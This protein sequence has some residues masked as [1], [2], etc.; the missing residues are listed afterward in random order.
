MRPVV[1]SRLGLLSVRTS[2]AN[3]PFS[4]DNT[5][6]RMKLYRN[7]ALNEGQ[8]HHDS[9][10]TLCTTGMSVYGIQHAQS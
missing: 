1:E 2:F 5:T 6:H 4:L 10:G 3:R 9:S 7:P 8:W